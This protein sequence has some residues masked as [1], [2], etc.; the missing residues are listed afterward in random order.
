M[1]IVTIFSSDYGYTFGSPVP[2][3]GT[4]NPFGGLDTSKAGAQILAGGGTI[5]RKATLGG[6]YSNYGL[7]RNQGAIYVPRRNFAG[8]T[9][10]STEPD[11][12][13]GSGS[14]SYGGALW[15]VTGAGTVY[16][17]ITPD[18]AGDLGLTAS[19]ESIDGSWTT[20][21]YFME[22]ATYGGTPRFTVTLNQGSLWRF[23]GALNAGAQ[24][25]R[26]RKLD[27]TNKQAYFGNGASL[28]YVADYQAATLSYQNKA[29]PGSQISQI[30]TW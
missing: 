19:R 8:T 1:T 10:N 30:E 15:K 5:T 6:A 23:T 17:D 13:L 2:V 27:S 16:T 21:N 7:V 11:Y 26:T 28:G 4:N 9:N 3:G 12:L 25:V 29:T 20:S 22:L 14:L 24:A 18:Y